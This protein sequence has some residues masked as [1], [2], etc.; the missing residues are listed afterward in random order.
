VDIAASLHVWRLRA[1]LTQEE[2]AERSGLSVRTISGLEAG[3][4]T[5][6]RAASL[7]LLADALG[8]SEVERARLTTSAHGS[9]GSGRSRSTPSNS[10]P[11]AL[12][13]FVGRGTAEGGGANPLHFAPPPAAPMAPL[14]VTAA[15]P[16]SPSER[17]PVN[18]WC[19]YRRAACTRSGRSRRRPIR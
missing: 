12:A 19:S 11:Y 1:G 2:L 4:R 14:P 8:L 15:C 7:R 9:D 18:R 10:L 3:Q 13:D 5:N 6:P 16:R 17:G